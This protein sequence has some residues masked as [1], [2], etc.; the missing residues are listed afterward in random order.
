MKTGGNTGRKIGI[1][2]GTFDPIHKAHL[3]VAVAARDTL[4]LQ[5][6]LVVPAANP[7]HKRQAMVSFPHRFR[8]VELACEG[9]EGLEPSMLEAG[10]QQSYSIRT[11]EKVRASIASDDV[12][13]FIIGADAF[14]EITTWHR[15]RDVV[16][17]VIFAVVSRPNA[18]YTVP[19]GAK[20]VPLTDVLMPVSSSQVRDAL[21]RGERP[22]AIPDKIYNYIRV[23]RLYR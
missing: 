18:E 15:W 16:S 11:I 1:F 7:P 13:Y 6:V 3:A 2:G 12:L 4:G 14:A 20:V 9:V 21:A 22:E 10:E 17:S 8:M 19:P 23:N 5:R